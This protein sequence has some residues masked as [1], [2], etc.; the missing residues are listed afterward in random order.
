MYKAL[1]SD[2]IKD[3]IDE[4]LEIRSLLLETNES[5]KQ[6]DIKEIGDGNLNFVYLVKSNKTSLILKQAVPYL[7]CVGEDYPLSTIRMTFEIEALK[8]QKR[9]CPSLVPEIFYS[10]HEMS[11]LVMQNL[12]KHKILRAEMIN[13][14]EFPFLSEHI[15]TFLADTLFYTSD[16]Y[17]SSSQK[18]ENVKKFT[19]IELCEITENFIFTHPFEDNETNEYNPKLEM[20]YVK[21]FR[22]DKQIKAAIL[23]MK[24]KFMTNAQAML[25]GDLHSGSIMLNKEE[26]YVIDPEFSFYGP[27]AFDVG[28]YLANLIL[29]YLSLGKEEI[30][31]K[32][33]VKS[34]IIDT[35][36]KFALKFKSN[37]LENEKK[38]KSL[39]FDYDNGLNDLEYYARQFIT[40]IF[41]DS[42]SFI[43][44]EMFRRTIGLAKVA[45]I[46]SIEDLELRAY[47]ETNVL[48]CASILIKSDLNNIH[49]LIKII[50]NNKINL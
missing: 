44:C 21:K 13:R 20:E 35:W 7:R 17:L 31:Y 8:T 18:K 26:T 43:S 38:K 24:Y 49:E 6:L 10:S 1:N 42:V 16:F 47:I 36:E 30:Q 4:T 33:Y 45:D 46:V 11:V 22:E 9:I 23:K 39:Q 15:S 28:I 29:S 3:Y 32:N 48:S 40:D 25:H 37:I 5:T 34:Q 12:N 14:V 27:I 2:L 41:K 50:E 19:N